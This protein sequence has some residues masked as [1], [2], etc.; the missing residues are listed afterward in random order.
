MNSRKRTVVFAILATCVEL[1]IATTFS[2]AYPAD[3]GGNLDIKAVEANVLAALND[4]HYITPG[5]ELT[6]GDAL[7]K[8]DDCYSSNDLQSAY[9]YRAEKWQQT[10][11]FPI[12]SKL[13]T[14]LPFNVKLEAT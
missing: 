2:K 9:S 12:W 3:G 7:K 4:K 8:Y 1:L 14:D 5:K 11:T 6:L 13:Y 10:V